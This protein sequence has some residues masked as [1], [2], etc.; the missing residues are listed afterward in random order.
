M[1]CLWIYFTISF[2]LKLSKKL[3]QNLNFVIGCVNGPQRKRYK[4][5]T[6]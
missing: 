3:I 4:T 5:K 1:I 2:R 6:F